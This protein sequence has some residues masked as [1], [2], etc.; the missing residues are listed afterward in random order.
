MKHGRIP[1]DFELGWRI[2]H[3]TIADPVN[4]PKY[5]AV[6]AAVLKAYDARSLVRAV[7]FTRRKAPPTNVT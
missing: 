2:G 5:L 4:Y 6:D 7:G 3:I 1:S